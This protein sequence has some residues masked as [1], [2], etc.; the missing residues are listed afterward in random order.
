MLPTIDSEKLSFL[1]H[2]K[3]EVK[4]DTGSGSENVSKKGCWSHM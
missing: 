3:T 2:V 4:G 1:E